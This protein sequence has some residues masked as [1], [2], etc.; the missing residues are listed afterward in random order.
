MKEFNIGDRVIVQ[1]LEK[2]AVIEDKLYSNKHDDWLYRVQLED[3]DHPYIRP[4]EGDELDEAPAEQSYRFEVTK[5]DNVVTAVMY[6]VSGNAER[7]VS[8]G[9]GHVIH[10]GEVGIAQAASYAMKKCYTAM[11]GGSYIGTEGTDD[12]VL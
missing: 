11:N 10:A 4:F 6:A 1:L 5:A 7:E 12:D 8:R 3:S 2:P 9:H